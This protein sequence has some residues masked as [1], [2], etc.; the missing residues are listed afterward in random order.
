MAEPISDLSYRDYQGRHVDLR[1]RWLVIAK[2]G[3]RTAFKKRSFWVF[4]IFAAWY[5]IVLIGFLYVMEQIGMARGPELIE[6]LLGRLEWKDQFLNGFVFTQVVWLAL[7]LLVGAGALANDN[8]TNALLVYLSKPCRKT[9]YLVGKWAGVFLPL[10]VGMAVPTL[11]FFVYGALNFRE[12]D[13]LTQ[14]GWLFVKLLAMLV[15]AAGFQASVIIG[16]SSLFNQGRMAGAAY[17]GAYF[18]TSF[19]SFLMWIAY[20]V[21]H[22]G[23]SRGNFLGASAERLYYLSFDGLQVGWAKLMLGT[24]GS[25]PFGATSRAPLLPVPPLGLVIVPMVGLSVL[26]VWLAWRRIRAVEVV[27]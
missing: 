5:Y 1:S 11:F 13:F 15:G 24:D 12:Y 20:M 21:S 17:A 3:W 9:D 8:G 7:G 6:Q 18:L 26:G 25:P 2:L 14:D 27:K 16:V 10:L 19:F 4:S 23:R 22:S